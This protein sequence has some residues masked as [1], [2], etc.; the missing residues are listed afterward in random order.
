MEILSVLTRI[1]YDI[2]SPTLP[3]VWQRLILVRGILDD[4]VH[5]KWLTYIR[6]RTLGRRF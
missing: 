3:S 5:T 4:S 1:D 2:V 6:F